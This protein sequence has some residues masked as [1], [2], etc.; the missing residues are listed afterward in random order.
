MAFGSLPAANNSRVLADAAAVVVAAEERFAVLAE[1]NKIAAV[2][3][4]AGPAGFAL[5]RITKV[6]S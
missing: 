3:V 6:H 2:S 5:E 4:E 1:G